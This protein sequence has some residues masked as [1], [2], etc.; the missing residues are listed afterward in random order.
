MSMIEM[1]TTNILLLLFTREKS[2]Y[3]KIILFAGIVYY[4]YISFKVITNPILIASIL[5]WV[6]YYY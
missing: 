4:S 3:E 6:V 1:R 5:T 2:L